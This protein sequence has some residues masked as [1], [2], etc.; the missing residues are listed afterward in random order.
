MARVPRDHS[1]QD[2]PRH[3]EKALDVG[4]DHVVPVVVLPLLHGVQAAGQSRV[5]D[6]DVGGHPL[7]LQASDEFIHLGAVP[8]VEGGGDALKPAGARDLPRQ[9]LQ[10]FAPAPGQHETHPHRGQGVRTGLADSGRRAGHDCG[11]SS[12]SIHGLGVNM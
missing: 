8:H 11:L 6:E 2:R 12:D 1:R 7:A 10:P 5:V 4:V 9:R 3:V